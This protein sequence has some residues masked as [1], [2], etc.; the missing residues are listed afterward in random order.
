VIL[1]IYCFCLF[2]YGISRRE[3]ALVDDLNILVICAA[4]MMTGFVFAGILPVSLLL[5][6]R[7]L[8]LY[9]GLWFTYMGASIINT[10]FQ[11]TI[12]PIGGPLF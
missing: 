1:S 5:L 7:W 6:T 11:K 4:A 12:L 8:F 3:K 10:M 2:C 9:I